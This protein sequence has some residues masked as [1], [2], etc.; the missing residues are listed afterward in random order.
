MFMIQ[1]L[2]KGGDLYH[3][4]DDPK[5][6]VALRWHNRSTLVLHLLHLANCVASWWLFIVYPLYCL[7]PRAFHQCDTALYAEGSFWRWTLPWVFASSTLLE[8]FIWTSSTACL[9]SQQGILDMLCTQDRH[10]ADLAMQST[11]MHC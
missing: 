5:Q 10:C 4:L 6:E 2:L 3:A 7:S 1:E 8:L 11:M 9:S